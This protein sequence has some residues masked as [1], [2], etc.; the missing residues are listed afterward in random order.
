MGQ[1]KLERGVRS[2][3]VMSYLLNHLKDRGLEPGD[4]LPGETELANSLGVSRNTVREAYIGLEADGV[5][6]RRHGIGTFVARQPLIKDLLLKE[7]YG[8]YARI[9][10]AGYVP[11]STGWDVSRQEPPMEAREVLD[12]GPEQDP[13]LCVERVIL[14]DAT[15]A[16]HIT[17]YFSPDLDTSGLADESFGGNVLEF[18]MASL[19]LNECRLHSRFTAV[20]ADAKVAKG[21]KLETGTAVVRITSVLSSSDSRPVS[22]A[23]AYLNPQVIEFE[24]DRTLW[25]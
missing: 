24:I 18:V 6:T 9:E 22:Y 19:R 1:L 14:A 23:I 8:F 16:V 2:Q 15:P 7:G 5:V 11:S 3:Q 20:G 10:A 12:L 25:R 17:D 21:L 4:Q 13:L